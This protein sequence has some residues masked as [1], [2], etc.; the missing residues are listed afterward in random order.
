MTIWWYEALLWSCASLTIT[1][2]S[3]SLMAPKLTWFKISYFL[4]RF[5]CLTLFRQFQPKVA[6]LKC[7]RPWIVL[8]SWLLGHDCL[9]SLALATCA[10]K[11]TPV[12]VCLQ[13]HWT[14]PGTDNFISEAGKWKRSPRLA[15]R[16]Q[17][18]IKSVSEELFRYPDSNAFNGFLDALAFLEEHFSLTDWL[19][20]FLKPPHQMYQHNYQMS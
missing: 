15:I 6:N 12:L 4:N 18:G 9:P 7:P 20:H 1:L 2:S 19:N 16:S 8:S 14:V 10:R 11:C 13:G 3:R 17:S 5:L